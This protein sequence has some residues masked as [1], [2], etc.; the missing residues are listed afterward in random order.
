MAKKV[1]FI[2]FTF[3][4]ATW[5]QFK[6]PLVNVFNITVVHFKQ[7]H[8]LKFFS[9]HYHHDNKI[10]LYFLH[11]SCSRK[12][13]ND[14]N[15]GQLPKHSSKKIYIFLSLLNSSVTIKSRKISVFHTALSI[16]S[17][18]QS[19]NSNVVSKSHHIWLRRWK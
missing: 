5:K 16:R 14:K 4:T 7:N 13:Q 17:Y 12:A 10:Y 2:V 6:V 1:L 19:R 18:F 9:C 3:N 8:C 11:I 15:V